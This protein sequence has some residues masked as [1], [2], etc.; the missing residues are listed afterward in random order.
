V[1]CATSS[2]AC[3]TCCDRHYQE[4]WHI[5]CTFMA[6]GKIWFILW[7]LLFIFLMCVTDD[8]YPCCRLMHDRRIIR[9]QWLIPPCTKPVKCVPQRDGELLGYWGK[10]KVKCSRLILEDCVFPSVDTASLCFNRTV[11]DWLPYTLVTCFEISISSSG[12]H[13]NKLSTL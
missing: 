11:T 9:T 2:P 3:R 8:A 4:R 12:R 6:V 1:R 13:V 5:T 7:C 10:S